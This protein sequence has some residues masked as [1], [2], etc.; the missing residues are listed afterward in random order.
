MATRMAQILADNVVTSPSATKKYMFACTLLRNDITD[1]IY[2]FVYCT[3]THTGFGFVTFQS[4]NVVDAVCDIHFHEINNKMVNCFGNER[5]RAR[6]TRPA[7]LIDV[8]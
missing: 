3:H 8:V 1:V 5:G 7:D 4:E 2:W 6:S